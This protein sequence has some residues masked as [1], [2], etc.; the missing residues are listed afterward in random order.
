MAFDWSVL[1]FFFQPGLLLDHHLVILAALWPGTVSVLF[2]HGM[3]RLAA[4]AAKLGLNDP[5]SHPQ[6]IIALSVVIL[7]SSPAGSAVPLQVCD[8]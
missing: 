7:V 2:E 6:N 1:P 4:P 5:S 8:V 3:A